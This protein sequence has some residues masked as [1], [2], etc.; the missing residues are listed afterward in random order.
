MGTSASPPIGKGP[1]WLLLALA[2]VAAVLYTI[3]IVIG[4]ALLVLVGTVVTT[5]LYFLVRSR[6]K[7]QQRDVDT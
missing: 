5:V 4:S 1:A 2:V 6:S 3:G 7:R